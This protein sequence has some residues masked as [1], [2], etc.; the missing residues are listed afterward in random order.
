[1]QA[2]ASSVSVGN[3]CDRITRRCGLN[4]WSGDC[5]EVAVA[6][7][8]ILNT[9]ISDPD[10]NVD[11]AVLVRIKQHGQSPDIVHASV[12]VGDRFVGLAPD[13]DDLIELW[14]TKDTEDKN[15]G[16][17]DWDYEILTYGIGSLLATNGQPLLERFAGLTKNHNGAP[18]FS[19]ERASQTMQ[20]ILHSQPKALL[21]YYVSGQ[22]T[23]TQGLLNTTSQP[24]GKPSMNS[25]N[26]HFI[27][28][29]MFDSGE[30]IT[31]EYQAET[32]FDAMY[33][34]ARYR[35]F[36]GDLCMVSAVEKFP[37][38]GAGVRVSF[39]SDE[40]A[41]GVY[42]SDFEQHSDTLDEKYPITNSEAPRG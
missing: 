31:D 29:G 2:L 23:P 11:V 33:L 13:S 20:S 17:R 3:E 25:D 32:G 36:D 27:V 28:I 18:V 24:Q 37:K 22:H 8:R 26:P 12:M 16:D 40:G 4:P 6:M 1:M 42:A 21:D 7:A 41:S 35:S 5:L 14:E 15:N 34:S 30:V 38:E 10:C 19:W 39:A 9:Q